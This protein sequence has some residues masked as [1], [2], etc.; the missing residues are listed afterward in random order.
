MER[1][2][3]LEPASGL[4]LVAG[5]WFGYS[6][7]VDRVAEMSGTDNGPRPKR[8]I[9]RVMITSRAGAQPKETPRGCLHIAQHID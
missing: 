9:V 5:S 2:M 4:T 8:G 7:S 3:L 1:P 6:S